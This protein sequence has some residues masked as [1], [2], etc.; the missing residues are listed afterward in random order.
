MKHAGILAVIIL[1]VLTSLPTQATAQELP[2][3]E[4]TVWQVYFVRTKPGMANEYLK[5]LAA[6]WRIQ[7]EE[8]KKQGLVVSYKILSGLPANKEDWDLMLMIEYKNMAA[9]DGINEKWAAIFAK[10]TGSQEK[11]ILA[12]TNRSEMRELFGTK[13]VREIILK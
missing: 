7:N 13:I 5:D 12:Y 3:K 10:I 4:G 11:Q 8:A 1:L 9:L 2:Y 6:E